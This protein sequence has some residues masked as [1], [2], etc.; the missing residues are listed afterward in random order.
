MPTPGRR[1]LAAF[2]NSAHTDSDDLYRRLGGSRPHLRRY[3]MT[4]PWSSSP[5]QHLGRS[6]SLAGTAPRVCAAG[7]LR[8]T[9]V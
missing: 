6:G 7:A 1:Q 2:S 3:L 8:S 9:G 4:R 5:P